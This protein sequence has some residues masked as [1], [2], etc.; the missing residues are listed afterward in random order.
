MCFDHL[1]HGNESIAVGEC[2]QTWKHRRHLDAGEALLGR[3]RIDHCDRQAQRKV[4]QIRERVSRI[5][6][7]RSE[8]R[9]DALVVDIGAV[10]SLFR[11]QIGPTQQC[12]T[13]T[14]QLRDQ[15]VEQDPLLANS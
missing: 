12:D 14:F 13:L 6:G 10:G 7:E 11:T 1:F 15:H 9:E 5:D 3:D 4:R 8:H 2:H